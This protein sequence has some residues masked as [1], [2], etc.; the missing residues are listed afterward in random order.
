MCLGIVDSSI[1]A[2]LE[3]CISGDDGKCEYV[4]QLILCYPLPWVVARL[5]LKGVDGA[6]KAKPAGTLYLRLM[7]E[8]D[9]GASALEQAQRRVG[10]IKFG[11]ASSTIMKTAGMIANS[12]S[13]VENFQS[14]LGNL[15]SKLEVLVN[16][17]DEI[18]TVALFP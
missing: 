9:A 7:L 8:A 11:P 15:L 14:A 16:L 1:A 18:A 12:S 3:K 4:G 10:K 17:G 2:L 5:Q 6:L 13:T